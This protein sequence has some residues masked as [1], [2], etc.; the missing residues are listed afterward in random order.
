MNTPKFLTA[1]EKKAIEI[2]SSKVK[3]KLGKEL[4]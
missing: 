2:F 1:K 4:I 3:E